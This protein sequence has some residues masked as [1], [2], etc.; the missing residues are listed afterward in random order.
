MDKLTN[1]VELQS[2]QLNCV[3]GGIMRYD[4]F[5]HYYPT[6]AGDNAI[7]EEFDITQNETVGLHLN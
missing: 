6:W 5:V 4:A 7:N 3:R 1:V 2:N